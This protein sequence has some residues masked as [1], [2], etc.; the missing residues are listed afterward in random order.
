M[1]EKYFTYMPNEFKNFVIQT[2]LNLGVQKI[3]SAKT[4][5][6]VKTFQPLSVD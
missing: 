2:L 5:K 3:Y 4:E 1:F 6:S